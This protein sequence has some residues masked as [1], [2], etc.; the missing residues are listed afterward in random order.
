MA[1]WYNVWMK[2]LLQRT[3]TWL[4]KHW[5]ITVFI[6]IVLLGLGYWF[7]SKQLKNETKLTF[8]TPIRQDIA[9]TL[10]V[11]GVV[12]ATQKARLR[13]AAGGKLT[14]LR[15]K[16][17]D[18]VEQYQTLAV[19]DQAALRKQLQQDLNNYLKERN[20]WDQVLDNTKDR[21]LPKNELRSKEKDQLDLNN[22]V[23]D[24]EIQSIAITNTVLSAPFPG[25]L[26]V[27]PA[28]SAGI[29]LSAT[30]YFELVNPKTLEFVAE[31]DEADIS[32]VTI[33]QSSQVTLDAYP[34]QT[35]QTYV[36]D[37]A[38]ASKQGENGTVFE[39]TFALDQSTLSQ[40][41]RLGMNGDVSIELDSRTGVLT[42][43][44]T[45]TRV[46]DDKTY[47][48]VRVTDTTYV[49][50]E[51]TTGLDSEDRVEV[52]SG[53]TEQDEILSPE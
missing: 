40:M 1:K 6:L 35:L 17:G 36:K 8:V 27:V 30:D 51:I 37:V 31:V 33:G 22:Q 23:L 28:V 52:L 43:P 3:L 10:S 15:V 38:F 2:V 12:D 47:V 4:Q 5:K 21:A 34:E 9:K 19:I 7:Y 50:R 26:T 32:K 13:F 20:D 18:A 41:L 11:S 53:V 14:S 49:E 48:D 42:I 16:K 46:R 24:V 25:I 39:V 44:I 29:Q 45:S